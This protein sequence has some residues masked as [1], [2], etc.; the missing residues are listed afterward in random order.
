MFLVGLL[1]WWYGNGWR[2]RLSRTGKQITSIAAF[3]SIGQ[4]ALTLF[5]PFRQISAGTVN[6]SAGAQLR[7][8][9]DKTISRV[10]GAFVRFFA[11]IAGLIVLLCSLII[12][13]CILAGWLLF[14]ALIVG[15]VVLTIVGWVPIKL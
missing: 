6:G 7:A 13:V 14:P 3:F 2:E 10:V 15:C 1:S 8:F 4:L 9:V 5:S 11:I 12:S